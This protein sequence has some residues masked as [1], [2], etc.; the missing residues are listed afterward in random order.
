MAMGIFQNI[1]KKQSILH[2]LFMATLSSGIFLSLEV[3]Y[4]DRTANA[5]AFQ[6]TEKYTGSAS[7]VRSIYDYCGLTARSFEHDTDTRNLQFTYIAAISKRHGDLVIQNI[8]A[9]PVKL[10]SLRTG[11]T[12]HFLCRTFA[13]ED[14]FIFRS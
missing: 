6:I 5:D 8:L 1:S 11:I 2:W 9:F 4:Y 3:S 10:I 7:N 14:P 13:S 12:Q